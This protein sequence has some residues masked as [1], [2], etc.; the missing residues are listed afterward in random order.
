MTEAVG[1]VGGH[2][3]LENRVQGHRLAQR[4][5]DLPVVEV[6]DAG[7]VLAEAELHRRAEHPRGV[8]LAAEHGPNSE[9]FGPAGQQGAGRS[10]RHQVIDVEV[11][12]PGQHPDRLTT[13]DVDVGELHPP[14]RLRHGRQ[15]DD[16]GDDDPGGAARDVLDLRPGLD[17]PLNQGVE[18]RVEH[19]VLAQP[20]EGDLH[21]WLTKRTSF[22]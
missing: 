4:L 20:V 2:L 12:G 9:W 21:A 3:D 15:A 16:A 14:G 11:G 10:V 22:S 5:A 19:R 17:E 7:G 6:K 13:A 1:P 8:V 18:R